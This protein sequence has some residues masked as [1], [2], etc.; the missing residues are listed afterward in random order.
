MTFP[1]CF[2]FL[3][4]CYKRKNG[5]YIR[6]RFVNN[7]VSISSKTFF[8]RFDFVYMEL[9]GTLL[10]FFSFFFFFSMWFLKDHSTRKE[11]LG[12]QKLFCL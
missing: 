7:S 8:T 3:E 5:G 6:T 4:Y 12:K 10:K 1:Q 9:G 2:F 11:A